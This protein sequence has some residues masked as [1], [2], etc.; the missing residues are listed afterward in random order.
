M[1][2]FNQHQAGICTGLVSARWA[3]PTIISLWHQSCLISWRKKTG[4]QKP[5][6]YFMTGRNPADG[7][8]IFV[9][10]FSLGDFLPP[11]NLPTL[12]LP[13]RSKTSELLL[14]ARRAGSPTRARSE[15]EAVYKPLLNSCP[16]GKSCE[17]SL[18]RLSLAASPR[19]WRRDPCERCT[20]LA[21]DDDAT[22]WGRGEVPQSLRDLR[23]SRVKGQL[24]CLRANR[25]RMWRS[26]RH[27]VHV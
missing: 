4:W 2:F 15:S 5:R 21:R 12:T 1:Q 14:S 10:L 11:I 24:A 13:V 19:S 3:Q 20:W 17:S 7:G 16:W 23:P 27:T 6:C 8:S 18:G 25:K 22:R 26:R 9:S